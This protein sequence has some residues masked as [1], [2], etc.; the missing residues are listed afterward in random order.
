LTEATLDS[1]PSL[2]LVS[3]DGSKTLVN[4]GEGCQRSF[5]EAVGGLRLRTVH[6][7]CLT[8]IGHDAIGGLPGMILT[9]ADSVDTTTTAL[10]RMST[11]TTT[12]T[13]NHVNAGE[14][15]KI[16]EKDDDARPGLEI[17]GPQG[18]T[19]FLQSLRHF[20]R[21]DRFQIAIHDKGPYESS[22][23][24]NNGDSTMRSKGKKSKKKNKKNEHTAVPEGFAVQ[25]IPIP[26]TYESPDA[27]SQGNQQVETS[28]TTTVEVVS[29]VFTTPPIPGKFQANKAKELGIPPGPLYAKLKSGQTVTFTS[30]DGTSE[31]TVRSD[32]VVEKGSPGVAV[33]VIYCPSIEVWSTLEKN[34][35]VQNLYR[36]K[37]DES[38]ETPI[39][40]VMVHLTPKNVFERT[41]YQSWMK[42]FGSDVEHITLHMGNSIASGIDEMDERRATPFHAAA[43]GGMTR[44]LVHSD[45][46]P[47][48]FPL[49]PVT[50]ASSHST[51]SSSTCESSLKVFR[52][53]PMMDYCLIPRAKRGLRGDTVQAKHEHG[54]SPD[55]R[56]DILSSGESSGAV[57]LSKEILASE[58]ENQL[59]SENET[60]ELIFT[61]TGSAIPCKHRNVTGM[62]LSMNNGNA[63]LLDV[64]EGTL[65][66]LLR[67]KRYHL[68]PT[69]NVSDYFQTLIRNIKAVWIS[70]P[71]ADHHLGLLRFLTE[72]NAICGV[73]VDPIV[74][75]APPSLFRFL[76]EYEV[77]DP[78]VRNSY[79]AVDCRDMEYEKTNPMGD[80]LHTDLGLTWCAAV[81]VSHCAHS[82]AVVM[83]GTSF[84]R[85]TYSGDCRPSH[86][87]ADVGRNSDLL[88]HEAT[89]LDEMKEEAA[90]KRHSTVGEA[91][92]VGLRMMSK[93][94][95]LTHFSQ[96]YPKIP[97]LSSS[98]IVNE[99]KAGIQSEENGENTSG[100][101]PSTSVGF[102]VV[103]AFDFMRLKPSTISTASKLSPALRLLY[104]GDDK[105]SEVE[106]EDDVVLSLE[107]NDE[108]VATAKE[109]LSVPG[110]FATK[111]IL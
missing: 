71:H 53:T 69:D 88:I 42:G 102:P 41:E 22:K 48:P 33:A 12:T 46:F 18:T 100:K 72:R 43:L 99:E 62:Y 110:M 27:R 95:V 40:E 82:Y 30:A 96:R 52:G 84:G 108:P 25:S 76:T 35:L 111:G 79:L 97:P 74:L 93:A 59:R 29:Y 81:P 17:V 61:G 31:R 2:L 38:G 65:G 67:A 36:S 14:K 11:T 9:V 26:Y 90:L 34:D 60:G 107:T 45:I 109:I 77:V 19:G 80:K 1:S 10:H 104:P 54:I 58:N 24:I 23:A 106:N 73:G 39:L 75:M 32:E 57:K 44:S 50:Q 47:S 63:M 101:C 64:G 7:V 103:F 8:H 92:D 91:L 21:R 55:E 15:R 56:T 51:S 68:K 89:F 83:D 86:L 94:V 4:C 66:Q 49:S 85:L 37:K 98:T 5:L 78:R 87:L 6:R 105:K 13:A 28:A 70:H 16:S 20:M 3:P